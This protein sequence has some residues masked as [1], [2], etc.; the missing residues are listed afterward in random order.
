M[1]RKLQTYV[2]RYEDRFCMVLNHSNAVDDAYIM[3]YQDVKMMFSEENL[4]RDGTRWMGSIREGVLELRAGAHKL[5]VARYHNA[6]GE[7]DP[8]ISKAPETPSGSEC[9]QLPIDIEEP[10]PRF[11]ALI[12]RVIR[13]TLEAR[14]LKRLYDFK[15]QVC[16]TRI[17][18]TASV[19]YVEVHHIRPL[20]GGHNGLDRR[21]NMLVLCPN[22]HAMFDLGMPRFLSTTS[23]WFDEGSH[24]PISKHPI[25]PRP[26]PITTSCTTRTPRQRSADRDALP[27]EQSVL[28]PL[29]ERKPESLGRVKWRNCL[30]APYKA[31]LVA[32]FSNCATIAEICQN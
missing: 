1:R 24:E 8:L 26:L 13:D 6:F 9:I 12:T 32:H 31:I 2:D 23:V 14:L 11:S 30:Y 18:P 29:G 19:F 17:E 22:H 10:P 3:P 5:N 20:G 4:E 21:E 25:S 7:F 15:C 28:S 16:G 27:K